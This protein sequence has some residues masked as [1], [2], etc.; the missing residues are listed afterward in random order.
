MILVHMY[1]ANLTVRVLPEA[2]EGVLNVIGNYYLLELLIVQYNI[3]SFDPI[4]NFDC[5]Q[6]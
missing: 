4:T 2:N 6:F 3:P 5:N 1:F